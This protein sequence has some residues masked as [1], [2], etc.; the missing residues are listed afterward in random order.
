MRKC[1][2][3]SIIKP[4]KKGVGVNAGDDDNDDSVAISPTKIS[5]N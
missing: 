5:R 1:F 3:A 4:K 2:A